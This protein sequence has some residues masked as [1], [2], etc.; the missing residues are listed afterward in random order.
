LLEPRQRRP[1][2]ESLEIVNPGW[3][4][5]PASHR[6]EQILA[7]FPGPVT[8]KPVTRPLEFCIA[9][10]V[11]VVAACLWGIW[12]GWG[13][14]GSSTWG[15]ALVAAF[16]AFA[17]TG[18]AVMQRTNSMTLDRDSFEVVYGFAKKK[19]RY[20]WKDVSAFEIQGTT[21]SRTGIWVVFD[22]ANKGG[23]TLAV[24]DRALGFRNSTIPEDYGMGEKQIAE[25][26]NHWRDR[27]L[28]RASGWDQRD[29]R[30]RNSS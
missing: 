1:A 17:G 3:G 29:Q 21:M 30:L 26:L 16:F 10:A 28:A 5:C 24:V 4:S 6:G 22:D 13:Q 14:K 7:R 18:M 12:Q 11:L 15:L 19:K 8:V 20:L 27:A 9:V 2:T 25:L 23:G